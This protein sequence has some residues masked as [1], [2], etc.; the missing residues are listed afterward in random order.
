MKKNFLALLLTLFLVPMVSNA[1]LVSITNDSTSGTGTLSAASAS[2]TGSVSS[3]HSGINGSFDD[4]WTVS[5]V[6]S[7]ESFSI[8]S[9]I[10][11]FASFNVEYRLDGASPWISYVAESSSAFAE[12]VTASI[13]NLSGF[14]LHIFGNAN[15]PQ[16]L[17]GTYQLTVNEVGSVSNV[18]VPAAVWLFGS[19]LM[20]LVG[21]SRRKSSS[22]EA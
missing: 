15:N 16:G 11:K 3:S 17:S 2:G 6:P 22:V 19:A 4:F 9:S 21:V 13:Q 18:P 1:A 7:S 14:Q 5:L 10:P 20:G 8:V 12:T